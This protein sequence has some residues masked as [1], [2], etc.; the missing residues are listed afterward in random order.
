MQEPEWYLLR[1]LIAP[2]QSKILSSVLSDGRENTRLELFELFIR[3][4]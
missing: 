3:E 2:S 1:H 4:L